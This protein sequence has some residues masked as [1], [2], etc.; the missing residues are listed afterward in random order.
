MM[1][2][3]PKKVVDYSNM[4]LFFELSKKL[5]GCR[6]VVLMGFHVE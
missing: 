3:Q 4:V 2:N 6:D 1:D 5:S